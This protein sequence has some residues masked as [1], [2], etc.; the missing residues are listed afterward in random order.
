MDGETK[1]SILQAVEG[2]LLESYKHLGRALG[3][4]FHHDSELTYFFTGT[5]LPLCNGVVRA[6]FTDSEADRRI[7]AV[8]DEA[9]ARQVPMLWLLGPSSSPADL[10]Q[11]LATR[12]WTPDEQVPG[13]YLELDR[14]ERADIPHLPGFVI[15]EVRDGDTMQE[16]L[17]VFCTGFGLPDPVKNVFL[18]LYAR[19]G[20]VPQGSVRYFLGTLDGE[21]VGTT[22]LTFESGLAGLYAVATLPQ[23]RRKGIGTIMTHDAT[24]A[25]RASGYK[26]GTLQATPMGLN[27]YRRLGWQECCLFKTYAYQPQKP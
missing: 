11:R 7:Q 16:W 18:G 9:N 4:E 8:M 19:H 25:A 15:S 20:F 10:E 5:P 12:H 1:L 21:A 13:M 17:R 3:A 23:V 24:L 14:Y 2:N 6:S 22:L 26:V 27:I